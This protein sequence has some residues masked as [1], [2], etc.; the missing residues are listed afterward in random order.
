MEHQPYFLAPA[1]Y[2]QP[3]GLL[4]L[5]TYL[6]TPQDSGEKGVTSKSTLSPS[7]PQMG[8]CPGSANQVHGQS[9]PAVWETWLFACQRNYHFRSAPT[10]SGSMGMMVHKAK[11][12]GC[13]YFIYM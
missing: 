10:S 5:G 13:T 9:V 3:S 8:K 6:K 2:W 1:L 12:K 4:L 7:L 11:M